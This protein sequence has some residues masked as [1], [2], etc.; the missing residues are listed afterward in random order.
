MNKKDEE[1]ALKREENIE[2]YN[3]YEQIRKERGL[4]NYQVA[5]KMKIGTAMFTH[6]KHGKYSPKIEKMQQIANI[7]GVSVDYLMGNTEIREVSFDY[8]NEPLLRAASR[9][10]KTNDMAKQLLDRRIKEQINISDYEY[11]LII[12]YRKANEGIKESIQ[13]LLDLPVVEEKKA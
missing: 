12:A 13:K 5:K 10:A 6:W 8:E 3:R 11:N 2:K 4:S 9:L 1:E 7:L